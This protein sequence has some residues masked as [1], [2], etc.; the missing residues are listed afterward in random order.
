MENT[1]NGSWVGLLALGA[2]TSIPAWAGCLPVAL[3]MQERRRARYG[4]CHSRW[5]RVGHRPAPCCGDAAQ[6]SC[7]YGRFSGALPAC[8]S[9]CLTIFNGHAVGWLRSARPGRLVVP[10]GVCARYPIMLPRFPSRRSRAAPTTRARGGA[11]IWS[12]VS[13]TMIHSAGYLSSPPRG[14]GVRTIGRGKLPQGVD[15]SRPGV[16]HRAGCDGRPTLVIT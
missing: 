14:R 11:G 10:H 16:G 3:G 1:L 8:S 6:P 2:S 15:Q 4:R 9:L 12:A 13:A 7:R 5:S